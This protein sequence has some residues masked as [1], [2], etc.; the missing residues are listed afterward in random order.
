MRMP[1]PKATVSAIEKTR[2]GERY[3]LRLF[4]SGL[5]ER[6]RRSIL[7]IKTIC[8]ENLRG[9]YDLEVVDIHQ[10]P[11]LARDEQIVATP[12]LVKML[13][14]PLQR[15][16]GDLSDRDGVLLG[17]DIKPWPNDGAQRTDTKAMSQVAYA[18]LE[19]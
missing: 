15:V 14:L 3:L 9:K 18:N 8:Q 17:L 13:P 5:T 10:E 1:C 6:S 11:A 12:T 16:V 19:R 4:V 2:A 7:S